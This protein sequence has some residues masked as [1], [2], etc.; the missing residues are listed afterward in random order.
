[1]KN[2]LSFVNIK[3]IGILSVFSVA[4]SI[5]ILNLFTPYLADDYV[6]LSHTVFD[7]K[8]FA[9]FIHFIKSFYLSWGG[10]VEGHLFYSV[11]LFVPPMIADLLNT[12]CYMAVTLF[13]YLICKGHRGHSLPMY[14][15]IHILLWTVVPDYGQVMFWLAGSANYLWTSLPVLSLL[16]LYR[17]Y[18]LSD[19]ALFAG[20]RYCLP[21]FILGFLAGFAME[22]MSAGMLVILTLYHLH[23]YKERRKIQVPIFFSYAGSLAGFA[24]LILAPG[25]RVRSRTDELHLL[26]GFKFL[27][28]SYYWLCFIG[29]LCVIWIVFIL[30]TRQ[31]AAGKHK[32]I[33]R[34]SIIYMCGALASAYC[35]M[36][37]P[38]SPERTWFIVCAYAIIANGILYHAL[39]PLQ[40]DIVRKTIAAA[41]FG[42]MILLLVSMTDTMI[43]SYEITV[44]TRARE[45]AILQ[46]KAEGRLDMQTP[47]ISH[48]YP[49]R[50]RHD[51][52]TGL[53]DITE[54]PDFWINRAV[55]GYYGIH[56]VT[57]TKP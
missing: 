15:S 55:A 6:N 52:L 14:L 38:S 36:A 46:Q 5:F 27:M 33:I 57:G 29:V 41:T 49:L 45:T 40:P 44:Q 17:R 10:R 43:S 48:P 30:F 50:A 8:N 51:A 47:I 31:L 20:R 1:M 23:F 2:K 32:R 26:P 25:N 11:L 19:G 42:A 16:Y 13:L 18:S 12:L 3:I 24:L 22:N 39:E 21:L 53:S 34:E 7:S 35:M 4:F 9:G 28:I 54:D 56:S 37:A